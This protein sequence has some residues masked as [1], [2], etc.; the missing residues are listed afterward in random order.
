MAE[1]RSGESVA[2]LNL[3]INCWSRRRRHVEDKITGLIRHGIP[4]HQCAVVLAVGTHRIDYGFSVDCGN[5]EWAVAEFIA[6][7][8]SLLRWT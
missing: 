1:F 7:L 2:N 3:G 5:L 6:G 4:L 8:R